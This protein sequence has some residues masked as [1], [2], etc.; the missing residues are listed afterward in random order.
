MVSASGDNLLVQ[1][2]G[3][4][5]GATVNVIAEGNN[6]Q[7]TLSGATGIHINWNGNVSASVSQNAFLVSGGTNTGFLVN[8]ASSTGLTTVSYTNN[9][10]T[11]EGGTDTAMHVVTVGAAQVNAA[12]NEIQFGA[13]SGTGF[14]FSVGASSNVNVTGN[15]IIDTTDGATG[16]LFDS[17]TA[18]STATISGNSI[19]L[20]NNGA[21]LTQGIVFSNVTDQT[22]GSATTLLNLSG[23][24]NNTIQ[25][26]STP[27]YVPSGTTTG[28]ITVNG[29]TMP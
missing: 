10:F 29:T 26:A 6:I 27:F 20:S 19:Q 3:G 13:T 15:V 1:S 17:I 21:L 24:Q 16:I 22:S 23:T 8:N 5:T 18:P 25:G 7:N 9:V 14:R 28:E 2:L 12:S 11:S 4:G